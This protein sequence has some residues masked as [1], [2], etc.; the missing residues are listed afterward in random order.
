M[1]IAVLHQLLLVSKHTPFSL[2]L[3]AN[4]D[5]LPT[6]VLHD[7]FLDLSIAFGLL[8][9]CITSTRDNIINS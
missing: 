3:L 2:Q 9:C 7:T 6:A 5:F 8:S 1:N 4:I